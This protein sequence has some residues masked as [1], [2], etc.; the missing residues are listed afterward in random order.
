MV[1]LLIYGFLLQLAF[2]HASANSPDDNLGTGDINGYRCNSHGVCLPGAEDIAVPPR[3]ILADNTCGDPPYNYYCPLVEGTA[4]FGCNS[5][6]VQNRHP[7]QFMIDRG[8]GF[9]TSNFETWWLSQNWWEWSQQHNQG[10]LTVNI[11]ISFNKSY[12]LT[13]DT[14]IT[15][16]FTKP[17]K[18]VLE[19]STDF[20]QTWIPLQYFAD[21]CQNRFRM[22]PSDLNCSINAVLCN[23]KYRGQV[24]GPVYFSFLNC[25][26]KQTFWDPNIQNLT[27]ATDLKLRLEFPETDGLHLNTQEEFLQKYFYAI[28][29]IQVFGRCQ[30][31]GHGKDCKFTEDKINGGYLNDPFCLC[32]HNTEGLNCER[33]E[34][35]YNN[36][37]WMPATSMEEPNQC[38][39]K[40]YIHI[41]AL[42]HICDKMLIV[43]RKQHL[44]FCIIANTR[45]INHIFLEC[46][47]H[48]HAESCT[49]NSTLGHGTCDNCEHNTT[50]YFCEQC[51]DKFYRNLSRA[52]NDEQV[53][54]GKCC[55]TI[56]HDTIPY[57]TT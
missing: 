47:C 55:T 42:F 31:H 8:A 10:P 35:L 1:W 19:K 38:E 56:P 7:P 37:T 21:D 43:L 45:Y 50:G 3:I 4:C 18:M 26:T 27:E 48:E 5:S 16:K 49:F 44:K 22:E 57:H 32:E 24:E 40:Y 39:S 51:D 52:L 25:Y 41:S 17:Q 6:S 12:V 14:R 20:G 54:L 34:A 2:N 53:C 46:E 9:S 28:S 15:F 33:C 29:D 36:K 30:C 13:G 23:E 11:S